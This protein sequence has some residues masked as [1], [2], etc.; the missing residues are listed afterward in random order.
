MKKAFSNFI[1][2]LFFMMMLFP[3][4]VFAIDFEKSVF[5]NT[6]RLAESYDLDDGFSDLDVGEVT[7]HSVFKDEDGNF[8]TLGQALQ[9]VFSLIKFAAP[10]LVIVLSTMDYIKAITSHDAEDLKKANGKFVKR[11][12]IGI[13]IFLLPYLLD[14]IFEIFGVYDIQ[15]CG[16]GK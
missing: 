12:V 2:I 10:I 16:I 11:L 8:N 3:K 5:I 6:T 14:F 9:D 4:N 15:T 13:L 7:C 1:I